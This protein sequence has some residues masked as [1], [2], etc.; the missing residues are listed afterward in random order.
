MTETKL[1][2]I[3]E[4]SFIRCRDLEAPLADRL[5]AFANELRRLGPRFA[6]AV[7]ALVS[8]L[9]ESDAGA[10][11]PK[12]GEPMPAFLLPDDQGRLVR[13]EDLLGKGPVALA[14]NRG[15]W[16][17]YCRINVDALARAEKEVAAEHRH[18]AAIVPDRQK[19][20]VWLRSEAKA[21]F[22]VLTDID[23]GY[24]MTLDLAFYVGDE[25]KHMMVSSGW[26][27]SVSQGTDNWMLP[28]PATFII[29]TDGIIHARF[30]DPDYRMRMAIEDLLAALRSA[31]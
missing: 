7:D 25:L 14:F 27:P 3:L 21:P 8:R 22:P 13:L 26:D 31:T 11:A 9:A 15:H 4:E 2:E 16:C 23:N 17:P 19:F 6:A 20:A 5:Q 28:I 30:I 10:T 29:G 12:V 18:V 1:S 24:A